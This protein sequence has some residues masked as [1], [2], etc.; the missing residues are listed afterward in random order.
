MLPAAS[1]GAKPQPAIGIGK[2][3]GTM[4]ADDAERLLERDVDAAGDRDLPAEQPLGRGRVVGQHV[5]DVAGL[6]AGVADGV[7][8]VGHL[9]LGQLLEVGVDLARRTGAAAGRGRPGLT[10][11]QAGPAALGRGDR[12]VGLLDV[13]EARSARPARSPG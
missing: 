12:R 3:H 11:R 8:G 9:E 13:G 1:A 4:I 5:A 6:P 2:F 10:A 7:A